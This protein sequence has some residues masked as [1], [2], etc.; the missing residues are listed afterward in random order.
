MCRIIVK[1]FSQ[2]SFFLLG[3]FDHWLARFNPNLER[4]RIP[5]YANAIAKQWE[6][7]RTCLKNF[8]IFRTTRSDC[9]FWKNSKAMNIVGVKNVY[10]NLIGMKGSPNN[11]IFP[12]I[13]SKAT[14]P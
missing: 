11:T 7:L 12:T 9:I 5:E 2:K 14:C 8:C 3:N 13:F 4:H 10:H 1:L 6:P